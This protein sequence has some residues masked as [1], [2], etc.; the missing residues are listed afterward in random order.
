MLWLAISLSVILVL[1]ALYACVWERPVLKSEVYPWRDRRLHKTLDQLT[2]EALAQM[3]LPEKVAQLS[4]DGGSPFL[5][6]LGINVLLLGR[7]PNTYS[8]RNDRLRIPPFSFSDGPRGVVVG[9]ATCFPVAMARAA[10]WDVSL[11]QRVGNVIGQEVRAAGANYFAGLCINL[12]RHPAWGRAQEC[13]GEDPH[14]TGAMGIALLQSVQRHH[15]MVC[16]KHFAAN[17]IEN[18][19][20]YVD[21][22]VDRRTLHE[23]YFPHFKKCVEA[24]V[25]SLMSAY[26]KVNGEYCG[27]NEYLLNDVLRKQW[28]FKGFITSD[29]LWGIYETRKPVVA[30]MDVEMP[31][32][33]HFGRKLVKA[34]RK[35]EVREEWVDRNVR[36]VL[37]TKLD[38]ISRA[39]H[40]AYA[41]SLLVCEPHC[42]LA[43]EVAEKSMVLLKNQDQLLPLVKSQPKKIAVIGALAREKNIGDHGSSR[44]S[45]PYVVSLWQ[46]LQQYVAAH[47]SSTSLQF[48]DGKNIYQA[49]A[50]AAQV[51]IVIM[52]AGYRH[53]DEGENLASNHKPGGKHKPAIG[54][55]RPSLSL[56][57]TDI[58]LIRQVTAAN[59]NTVVTLVGGSAIVCSEWDDKVKSILM[60]WYPGMEGGHAWARILFG[61]VNPSGKLP[62]SIPKKSD[63]L[64]PFDPFA[65]TVSYGYYHGY[66]YLDK[67]QM[68]PAYPFGFGLSYTSFSYMMLTLDLQEWLTDA[69]GED[70]TLTVGVHIKNTGTM[71]GE[72]VVQVYIG[73]D[74][75]AAKTGMERH[76][77]LLRGF[78]KTH[79]APGED[80][81]LS[82]DLSLDDLKRFDPITESWVIDEGE[83]VVMAGPSSDSRHL[84]QETI[85]VA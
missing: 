53:N 32:G 68:E 31:Y 24:G 75:V 77:K 1:V 15:V 52:V 33:R 62:F 44:V 82:F 11:E 43:Q 16:A 78:K 25:A 59:G 49:A 36:R 70:R 46:G 7:F 72:E 63:D 42:A 2:D 37:R 5:L 69:K 38:F 14:L 34:V 76:P 54:G 27:H 66:T 64:V 30:G 48:D 57:Q 47:A 39:D 65:E 85:T 28:N 12:L 23:V 55:D 56:H 71:T 79:L 26:N 58:D 40:Q 81:V 10:S 83:Y 18:S 45:P 21:T 74:K 3:T 80:T 41:P 17:S 20:F 4:G 50:L 61:D 19:R 67:Q 73:F 29:W 8:G 51:D 22:R 13:Y 35:G 84:L 6:R 9:K 60:A